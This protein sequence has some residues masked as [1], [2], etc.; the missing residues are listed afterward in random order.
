MMKIYVYTLTQKNRS[1]E[2]YYFLQNRPASHARTYFYVLEGHGGLPSRHPASKTIIVE[3][4]ELYKG[5]NNFHSSSPR[6]WKRKL[7]S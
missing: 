4:I 2:F 3:K 7:K 6:T 1:L 5:L